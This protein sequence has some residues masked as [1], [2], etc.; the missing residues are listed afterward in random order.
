MW[1][2]IMRL[3]RNDES[4]LLLDVDIALK[5]GLCT[6]RNN[7]GGLALFAH[8]GIAIAEDTD[9]TIAEAKGRL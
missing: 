4:G 2:D 1:V 9:F 6:S 7:K 5:D 8:R 3:L